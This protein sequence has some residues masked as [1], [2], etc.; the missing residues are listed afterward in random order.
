M[1]ENLEKMLQSTRVIVHFLGEIF[2]KQMKKLLSTQFPSA[3][4]WILFIFTQ[5]FIPMCM[6][7]IRYITIY[8][9][10]FFAIKLY[11]ESHMLTLVLAA[12]HNTEGNLNFP[13]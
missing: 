11:I 7:N 2:Q 12:S 3:R 4:E 9:C 8:E 5:L 6:C 13:F 10:T 1:I